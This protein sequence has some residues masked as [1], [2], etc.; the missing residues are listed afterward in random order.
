MSDSYPYA[1]DVLGDELLLRV[2]E[3][4]PIVPADVLSATGAAAARVFALAT[5]RPLAPARRVAWPWI[6]WRGRRRVG[7]LSWAT[8]GLAAVVAAAVA[9]M[10]SL[11]GGPSIVE[12]AYA[13]TNPAG[14]IVHYVETTQGS[15]PADR[16]KVTYWLDGANSRQIIDI[17]KPQL[18][19]DIVTTRSRLENLGLG[20]LTFEPLGP[21]TTRCPAELALLGDCAGVPNSTP[22]EGLRGLLHSGA[23]HAAGHTTIRGRRLDVLVGS[24]TGQMG[25]L[26]IRALVDARTFILAKVTM[27]DA[28]PTGR[29][30]GDAKHGVVNTLTI[31]GYQRLAVTPQN[32][33]HLA[34][35]AHPRVR[36]IRLRACPTKKLPNKLCR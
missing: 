7:L 36:V 21:L 4:A 1:D 32:L 26:R 27:I 15:V 22:L 2:R 34:L 17:G 16:Q 25:L 24:V 18:L 33:R 5:A 20:M 28:L 8:T 6:T 12:R 31:T 10:V 9:L 13:A 3:D 23:I 11:G 35:P 30:K 14:V 19:Q 29:A